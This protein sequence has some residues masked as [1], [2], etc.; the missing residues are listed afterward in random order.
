MIDWECDKRN[1]DGWEWRFPKPK[2]VNNEQK[3]HDEIQNQQTINLYFSKA[4]EISTTMYITK[5]PSSYKSKDSWRM[6]EK[7]GVVV[8]VYITRKLSKVGR[9][10]LFVRFIHVEAAHAL[11]R[12]LCEVWIGNYHI[13][14][15]IARFPCKENIGNTTRMF[16]YFMKIGTTTNMHEIGEGC[17]KTFSSILKRIR[18]SGTRK[19]K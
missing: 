9:R 2:K 15:S 4:E 12:K 13:F 6:C 3:R 11:D 8:D 10:F 16:N 5:F 17:A 14:A 18:D 7:H 19:H 1:N